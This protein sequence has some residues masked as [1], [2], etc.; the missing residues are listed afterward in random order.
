[1]ADTAVLERPADTGAVAPEATETTPEVGIRWEFGDSAGG[2]AAETE[3]VETPEALVAEPDAEPA[4]D[5]EPEAESNPFEGLDAKAAKE[6]AAKMLADAEK[7]IEARARESERQR[8]QATAK[9]QTRQGYAELVRRAQQRGPAQARQFLERG[10]SQVIQRAAE[11]GEAHQFNPQV[12]DGALAQMAQDI[13]VAQWEGFNAEHRNIIDELGYKLD[14]DDLE[15]VHDAHTAGD[16]AMA[17]RTW[18]HLMYKAA[19]AAAYSE[20]KR[21][22]EKEL[23]AVQKLKETH[24]AVGKANAQPQPLRVSGSTARQNF[25]QIIRG[26][27]G[28]TDALVEK[29]RAFEAKHGVKLS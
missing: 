11:T 28:G 14:A 27:S 26:T 6:L 8:A 29:M 21:D 5:A 19:Y 10:F 12:L 7:N 2:D 24:E 25:D 16:P 18:T 1:M 20:A 17:A 13:S 4:D 3:H 23:G 22:V 9:A 15:K